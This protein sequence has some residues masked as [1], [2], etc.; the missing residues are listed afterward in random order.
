[1]VAAAHP[2]EV[3]MSSTWACRIGRSSGASRTMPDAEA[4]A[5]CV[6]RD[7][8]NNRLAE[9]HS[10]TKTDSVS[11]RPSMGVTSFRTVFRHLH[12]GEESTDSRYEVRFCAG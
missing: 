3:I 12:F 10:S 11:L 9:K 2:V 8:A 7:C 5:P 1:M 4:V 6:T